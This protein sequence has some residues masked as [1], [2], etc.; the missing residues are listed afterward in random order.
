MVGFKTYSIRLLASKKREIDTM[1][2]APRNWVKLNV[3]GASRGNPG[4]RRGAEESFEATRGIGFEVL[5]QS[6]EDVLRLKPSF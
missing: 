3:D 2:Y 1:V 6:V 4:T 5:L